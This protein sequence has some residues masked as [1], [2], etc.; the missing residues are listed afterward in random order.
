MKSSIHKYTALFML[1]ASLLSSCQKDD[2]YEISGDPEVKFFLNNTAAANAP[3]NS[4]GFD[5]VNIPDV[6]GSGWV[7]LSTSLPGTVKFPV[8][9]NKAVGQDV[10]ISA[11]L[12][13]TLVAKYNA[14]NNTDYAV[15]PAGI[16]NSNGLSARIVKGTSTSTDSITITTNAAAINTLTR[17]AYMAPVKITAV[18]DPAAGKV[19]TN[20]AS[21]VAYIIVNTE[22][23]RIKYLAVAADAQGALLTGR[24]AWGVTFSPAPATTGGVVDGSNTTYSRWTASPVTVNVNLQSAKNV[25]GLRLYTATSTTYTPTQV[26]VSVSNDGI[27]YDIVGAPLKANLTYAS[28]Y[29]Y[30]LF[31]K[32]IQ[33]QYIR[34]KL[35]YSTSTNTQNLRL[36]ELDVYAN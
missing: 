19:T 35:S 15:L 29:N 23:R 21:Q 12:D 13:T 4:V 28:S 36:G 27:N 5:A 31:Y 34:L 33:A 6:A 17:K 7:N 22:L 20:A 32:A 9:A 14:A 26:E 11:V 25:T 18:S 24:T 3:A 2:T 10:V 30:I 16:L 8:F 1:A